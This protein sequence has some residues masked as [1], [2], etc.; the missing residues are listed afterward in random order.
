MKMTLSELDDRTAVFT[1]TTAGIQTI[2]EQ[3]GYVIPRDRWMVL[4][5]PTE[6]Q[7]EVTWPHPPTIGDRS[8]R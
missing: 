6:V 7:V 3:H 5:Q 8:S 2:Q 4:G 1:G